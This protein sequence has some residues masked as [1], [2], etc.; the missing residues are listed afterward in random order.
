ML[1]RAIRIRDNTHVIV[2]AF[3]KSVYFKLADGKGKVQNFIFRLLS[4]NN[5]K[6]FPFAH[7]KTSVVSKEYSPLKTLTILF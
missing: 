6:F 4:S 3:K 1:Y 5:W 7:T 2:K